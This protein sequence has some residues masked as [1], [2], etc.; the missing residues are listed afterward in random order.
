MFV[1]TILSTFS[2]A[3]LSR[4]LI[5]E[6]MYLPAQFGLIGGPVL[7]LYFC[8]SLCPDLAFFFILHLLLADK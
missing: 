4:N 1:N 3:K 2:W 6:E 5:D 7:I 8:T